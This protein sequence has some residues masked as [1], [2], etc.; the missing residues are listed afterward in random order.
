MFV[1]QRTGQW[2]C[3]TCQNNLRYHILPKRLFSAYSM[4]WQAT[5]SLPPGLILR[6]QKMAL[7]HAEL[8]KKA[9][10]M[11]DY[12][13]ESVQLYKRINELADIASNLKEFEDAQTVAS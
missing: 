13:P 1:G 6:A 2:I 5:Q 9:A 12:T 10:A 11:T 4:V 8:E 7:V 3:R